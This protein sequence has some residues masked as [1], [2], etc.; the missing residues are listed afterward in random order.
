M[1]EKYKYLSKY[2]ITNTCNISHKAIL[3]CIVIEILA[4]ILYGNGNGPFVLAARCTVSF[5]WSATVTSLYITRNPK[6]NPY[7]VIAKNGAIRSS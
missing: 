2:K 3:T 6:A 7:V 1:R 5:L 4:M